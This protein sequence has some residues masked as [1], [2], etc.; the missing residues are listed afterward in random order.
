MRAYIVGE[1][2]QGSSHLHKYKNKRA[3]I[4]SWEKQTSQ[5]LLIQSDADTCT[6]RDENLMQSPH[7]CTKKK[8]KNVEL[9]TEKT[10]VLLWKRGLE[11]HYS[12]N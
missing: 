12:G 1:R 7:L 8:E 9:R 10:D 4:N 2:K 6:A 5:T 3:S 11:E